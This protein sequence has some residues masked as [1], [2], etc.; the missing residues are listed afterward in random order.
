MKSIL[1]LR[2]WESV[3]LPLKQSALAYD[4]LVL[5]VH[6]DLSGTPISLKHLFV[7]L[8]YSEAGIRKQIRRLLKEGWIK[9]EGI[10]DDKRVRV[11]IAQP[12]LLDAMTNYASVFEQMT[13]VK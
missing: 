2:A 9:L 6:S 12:K 8:K 3:H 4:L 10:K 5:V 1:S 11:I 13:S 7:T